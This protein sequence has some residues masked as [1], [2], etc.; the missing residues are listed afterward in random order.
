[1][2][3][4]A[5]QITSL[6]IVYSTVY[7]KHR[8]KKTSKLRVTGLCAGKSPVTGE[9]PAQRASDAE[10][11][12]IWWR[13][14]EQ[15]WNVYIGWDVLQAGVKWRIILCISGV[16]IQGPLANIRQASL[17]AV[18]PIWA[19]AFNSINSRISTFNDVNMIMCVIAP[20][21]S[22]RG[23]DW[24]TCLGAS[25]SVVDPVSAKY[26]SLPDMSDVCLTFTEQF[27]NVLHSIIRQ[28]SDV[29]L[30]HFAYTVDQLKLQ[31]T[32]H[33]KAKSVL[34]LRICMSTCTYYLYGWG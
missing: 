31:T 26:V 13:H 18:P 19:R 34:T 29:S 28:M 24:A 8:S 23:T 33:F 22:G 10:N 27:Y 9:F 5:S 2:S 1:M 11:G 16:E 4:I 15:S 6:A 21:F 12:S 32:W 20:V 7:L 30:P 14:H 17:K 25:S 3:V